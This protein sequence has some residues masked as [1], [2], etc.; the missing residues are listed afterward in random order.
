[1]KALNSIDR[2]QLKDY[3]REA[4]ELGITLQELLSFLILE[5]LDDLSVTT[6]PAE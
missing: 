3:Q 1:M 6:Y 2:M 5:K 4:E